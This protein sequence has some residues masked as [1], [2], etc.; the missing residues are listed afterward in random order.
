M[1]QPNYRKSVGHF[2]LILSACGFIFTPPLSHSKALKN[3]IIQP[4]QQVEQDDSSAPVID[5]KWRYTRYGWQKPADWY[6][7]PAN[8]QLRTIDQ[9]NPLLWAMSVLLAVAGIMI[10]ASDEW[11]VARLFDRDKS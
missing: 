11:Q 3:S 10:W 7:T 2:L 1:A 5:T 6:R 8:V 9:I 4:T